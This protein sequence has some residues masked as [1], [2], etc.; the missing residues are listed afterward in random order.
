M[1]DEIET[2]TPEQL[3]GWQLY[4]AREPQGWER[5][6]YLFANTTQ[7]LTSC[8]AKRPP[9]LDDVMLKFKVRDSDLSSEEQNKKRTLMLK[10]MQA[11]ATMH[12]KT[13][14]KEEKKND[15]ELQ[16]DILPPQG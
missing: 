4:L 6:D 13:L 2:L 8:W 11:F 10:K 12:N 3:L 14:K 1:D 9:K 16:G 7:I 5:L 15:D